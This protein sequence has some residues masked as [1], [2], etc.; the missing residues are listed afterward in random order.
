MTTATERVSHGN[1]SADYLSCQR[2]EWQ[3]IFGTGEIL[4]TRETMLLWAHECE[5]L[6]G[7]FQVL[8]FWVL[9]TLNNPQ[10][11]EQWHEI[12]TEFTRLVP[13]YN[14]GN[15]GTQYGDLPGRTR[16]NLVLFMGLV[17]DSMEKKLLANGSI[18]KDTPGW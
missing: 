4:R 10:R 12:E 11:A 2:S 6:Y 3:R 7:V 13:E 18:T 8:R 1:I 16:E 9:G 17:C 14:R 5:S 15:F